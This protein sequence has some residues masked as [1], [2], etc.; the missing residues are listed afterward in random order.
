MCVRDFTYPLRSEN[1]VRRPDRD[2]ATIE[3]MESPVKGVV[4]NL[5][6]EAVVEKFGADIWDDLLDDAGVSRRLHLAR[7]LHR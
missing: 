6:E 4:Y 2:F 5:L 3:F 7:Q 1:T